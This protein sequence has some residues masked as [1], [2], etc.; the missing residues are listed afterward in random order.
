MRSVDQN[1]TPARGSDLLAAC[2]TVSKSY[3]DHSQLG[4]NR[5]WSWQ[6]RVRYWNQKRAKQ[7]HSV[8]TESFSLLHRMATPVQRFN[9][10]LP[11]H[12]AFRSLAGCRAWSIYQLREGQLT[13]PAWVE[14]RASPTQTLI[15]SAIGLDQPVALQ[16]A[17]WRDF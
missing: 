4:A 9:T 14:H 16:G 13:V 12:C 17:Q 15:L 11:P 3:S 10:V 6:T 5:M 1:S 2:N 8:R 7:W